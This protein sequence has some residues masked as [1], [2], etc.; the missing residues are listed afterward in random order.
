MRQQTHG[1]RIHDEFHPIQFIAMPQWQKTIFGKFLT[2]GATVFTFL[3][4]R[5]KYGVYAYMLFHLDHLFGHTQ[6]AKNQN[7]TIFGFDI[8]W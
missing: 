4:T 5:D 6:A 1:L 3:L 7:V 8:L 2:V